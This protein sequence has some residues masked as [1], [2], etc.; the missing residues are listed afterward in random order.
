M[1]FLNML[2]SIYALKNGSNCTYIRVTAK[3]C[4]PLVIFGTVFENNILQKYL[5]CSAIY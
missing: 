5:I 4:Q 3:K 1:W 2:L